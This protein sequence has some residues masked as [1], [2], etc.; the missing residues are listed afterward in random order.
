MEVVKA[1]P[2]L[3][4]SAPSRLYNMIIGQGTSPTAEKVL[5]PG[6]EDLVKYNFFDGQIFGVDESI[7]DIVKFLHAGAR[8]TETGKRILMLVGPVS[9]GKSSISS[10]LKKRLEEYS[11][12]MPIYAIDGCPMSEEPLHLVPRHDRAKWEDIL[13]G[14][15][16]EGDLCP[17][18]GISSGKK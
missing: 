6:Y 7:H 10:L 14:V 5:L 8:R 11:A 1:N 17:I 2:S 16:I 3:A 15:K 4:M 9:S 12:S 13:G 18:R